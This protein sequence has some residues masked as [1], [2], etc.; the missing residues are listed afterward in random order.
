MNSMFT[1]YAN[2]ARCFVYL[3]DVS[4]TELPPQP[5]A[6]EWVSRGWTLQEL[7][8][9]GWQ[10][11]VFFNRDW[12][13]LGS[14]RD[15]R[16]AIEQRA[17][18]SPKHLEDHTSACAAVKLSCQ[19]SFVEDR[20]YSLLGLFD[21][22]QLDIQYGAGRA[23]SV[24]QEFQE[25]IIAGTRDESI[26]AWQAPLAK[27]HS[28]IAPSIECFRDAG[29]LTIDSPKYRPRSLNAHRVAQGTLVFRLPTV[30]RFSTVFIRP[31]DRHF[32]QSKTMTSYDVTLNCWRTDGDDD[33]D[34][35]C[36]QLSKDKTSG[37]W[38]RSNCAELDWVKSV[39][40]SSAV[41]GHDRTMEF[42]IPYD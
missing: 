21:N 40:N 15:L 19:A 5:Q 23:Q 18:I 2:A 31:G 6:I 36:V 38:R 33:N 29:N 34:T 30:S 10:T 22:M 12:Q 41:V 28:M 14:K 35:A 17:R 27:S 26:F 8:A 16:T 7:L 42:Q 11:T 24:F 39:R 32:I 1:W 13:F 20:V 3:A 9:A 4:S 37:V 25:K